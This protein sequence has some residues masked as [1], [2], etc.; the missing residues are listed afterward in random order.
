MNKIFISLL[1]TI[2]EKMCERHSICM[3]NYSNTLARH[4]LLS[5]E[6]AIV[7]LCP[8]TA[9][10]GTAVVVASVSTSSVFLISNGIMFEMESKCFWKPRE[11]ENIN[12]KRLFYWL[13]VNEITYKNNI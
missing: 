4:Y 12:T 10:L 3:S 2:T 8:F 13:E 1:K 9:V 6:E 11:R 7:S 5:Q